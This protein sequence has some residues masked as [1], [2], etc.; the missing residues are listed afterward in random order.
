M[1]VLIACD[2]FKGSLTA[3]EAC[4]AIRTGLLSTVS[5]SPCEIR[6]LPVADGGD[7]IARTLTE[8]LSGEWVTA[9][10]SNAL[11]EPVTAGY[12]LLDR[13]QS[14]VIEMAEASG[15]ARLR[16]RQ[17]P[18]QANTFGT[19]E[20]VRDAMAAG[21]RK[22][23]L[24]IGGSASNDGG[25]GLARAL[26][27][28]FRD[29]R[30]REITDLPRSLS[31]VAEIVPPQP[32]ELPEVVVA[33]DVVNPL[34]GPDGATR[35]YG[36]Q[37]GI[38][39]NDFAKH[40]SGLSHLVTLLRAGKAAATPGAGAAGGLGFGCLVF[41]GATLT[42]GFDLVSKILDLENAVAAADLVITGEGKLDLQS[43]EGK[44][45][46]GVANLARKHGKRLV[47]FCGVKGDE[48]LESQFGEIIEIRNPAESTADNIAKG[49]GNLIAA[50]MDLGRRL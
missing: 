2:K 13:G 10:V 22:V 3:G 29:A 9:P 37:K 33:C 27:W 45:P 14:A 41:L 44:A 18:W 25:T 36:P 7:G 8:A 49:R 28:K 30:G 4:D 42:P 31:Q 21:V 20:L 46:Y 24:G 50:A 32:R 23:I 38:L 1:I 11:G 12:G 6:T 39:E 34:L 19:G 40:E 35:I 15:L 5:A 43:L 16:G 47:T 26:G 48:G 17:D